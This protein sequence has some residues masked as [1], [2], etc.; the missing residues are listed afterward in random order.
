MFSP[1]TMF[2]DQASRSTADGGGR[3]HALRQPPR[4]DRLRVS[5]G[6][7]ERDRARRVETAGALRQR[8]VVDPA[9]RQFSAVYCR[10]GFHRVGVSAG[11]AHAAMP[12]LLV[13]LEHERDGAAGDGGGHARAA[14]LQIGL[15]CCAC[16]G[17]SDSF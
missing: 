3:R 6:W 10:I 1:H 9:H 11:P 7:R 12:L 8:V 15:P 5:I 17:W 4:V 13:R 14:Q 2:C 16:A